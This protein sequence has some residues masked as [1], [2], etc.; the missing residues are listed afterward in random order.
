MERR[1]DLEE[2]IDEMHADKFKDNK[3]KQ[4]VLYKMWVG[5]KY[6]RLGSGNRVPVHDC[7]RRLI[8]RKF[9]P[10]VGTTVTGYKA[11]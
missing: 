1:E 2:A 10:L 11:V 4:Y 6:G 5:W 7:I 8:L 3:A 9:P